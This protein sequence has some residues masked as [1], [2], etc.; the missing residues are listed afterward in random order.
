M[1]HFKGL[2][3][4][5]NLCAT[6]TKEIRLLFIKSD[7]FKLDKFKLKVIKIFVNQV[8]RKSNLIKYSKNIHVNSLGREECS[9]A[10]AKVF[11]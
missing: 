9:T 10:F 4:T 2:H 7:K 5:L 8:F 3:I 1:L 11:Y 6:T